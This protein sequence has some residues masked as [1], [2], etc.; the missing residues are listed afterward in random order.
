[1]KLTL[2]LLQVVLPLAINVIGGIIVFRLVDR[3]KQLIAFIA[4]VILT[5]IAVSSGWSE[6]P[7]IVVVPNFLGKF[8]DPAKDFGSDMGLH[9]VVTVGNYGPCQGRVVSQSLPPET[10]IHIGAQIELTVSRGSPV[11][12]GLGHPIELCF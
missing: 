9:P 3:R 10:E 8:G 2:L 7:K 1:M 5:A 11:P 6:T 4:M 12:F